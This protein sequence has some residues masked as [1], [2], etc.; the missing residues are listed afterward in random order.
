MW[1]RWLWT[2]GARA[3][4]ARTAR[5]SLF[6]SYET[7]SKENEMF[8]LFWIIERVT[9]QGAKTYCQ[10][11]KLDT[12]TDNRH[13]SSIYFL[14]HSHYIPRPR[15]T[16]THTNNFSKKTMGAITLRPCATTAHPLAKTEKDSVRRVAPAISICIP[17]A[18]LQQ[19]G[20]SK[21]SKW[22]NS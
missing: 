2:L 17:H 13:N 21:K 14:K 22:C 8:L 5:G 10:A 19:I 6:I 11:E 1:H 9:G 3:L 18:D 20:T 12:A 16:H 7:I 4:L 15:H